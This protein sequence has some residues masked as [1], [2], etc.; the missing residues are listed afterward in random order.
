M[1]EELVKVQKEVKEASEMN[2]AEQ[3]INNNEFQFEFE[4]K[5]YR[6]R[7]PTFSERQQIFEERV[8]LWVELLK[9]GKYPLEVELRKLYQSRGTSI[10]KIDEELKLVSNKYNQ[11][12]LTL[13]KL[14]K[15][16]GAEKDCEVLKKEIEDL[17]V[18]QSEITGQKASL[19]QYS[20]E[21][22]TLLRIYTYLTTLVAESL[23][24]DNSWKRVYSNI[25]DFHSKNQDDL[26]SKFLMYVSLF[27]R[28]ELEF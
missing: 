10:E 28:H 17:L 25:D 16:N 8:R 1:S 11:A 27:I 3:L 13:G 22:Q 24:E 7:K 2:I 14:I 4:N 18:R 23:S 9:S 6:I 20:L 21:T 12:Q 15:E 26:S 19:F 5:K